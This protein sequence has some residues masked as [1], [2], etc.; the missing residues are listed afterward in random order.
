MNVFPAVS[1]PRLLSGSLDKR[2]LDGVDIG[3][4]QKSCRKSRISVKLV[5]QVYDEETIH[6]VTSG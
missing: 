4:I 5:I 1:R 2:S 6:A 3:M